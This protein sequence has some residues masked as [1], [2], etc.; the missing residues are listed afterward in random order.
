MTGYQSK[1]AAAQDKLES[2]EREALKLALDALEHLIENKS[3]HYTY[4]DKAEQAI[5]AIKEALAQPAQEPVVGTKTWFEDGKVVTQYLTA[6]DLYKEP[7]Q[8]PMAYLPPTPSPENALYTP[9]QRT[10]VSL[11]EDELVQIG[12][13][14]GLE[15]AAVEMIS[16]KLKEKNT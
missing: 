5:T 7:E 13:A 12:V 8:E 6:K 15:R 3:L 1:K 14:T 11:T 2:M 10:W 4:R 16:N 9:P